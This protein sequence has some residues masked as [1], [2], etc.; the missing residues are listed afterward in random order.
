MHAASG[1]F[2]HRRRRVRSSGA[3]VDGNLNCKVVTMTYA[4]MGLVFATF[5]GIGTV[6]VYGSE[7]LLSNPWAEY[8]FW[9]L[10]GT[11]VLLAVA[12]EL[13]RVRVSLRRWLALVVPSKEAIARS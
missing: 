5:F 1:R 3:G 4:L 6:M 11:G 8:V 10:I 12:D 2:R 13:S 9:W 7:G